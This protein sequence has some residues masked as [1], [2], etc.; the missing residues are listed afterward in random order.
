MAYAY[1]VEGRKRIKLDGFDPGDTAGL[2]QKSAE[3]KTGKY[4]RELIELQELL[5]AA[6]S[7][8]LLIILQGRDTSG[9]DG[10]I[11][12][13]LANHRLIFLRSHLTKR[14]T[15]KCL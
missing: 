9:K 7:Q 2:N 13:K 4:I 5:Y 8:S 14:A 15:P 10:T 6:G 3:A 12:M 1:R 11:R